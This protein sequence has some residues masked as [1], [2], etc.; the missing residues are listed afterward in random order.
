MSEAAA[1]SGKRKLRLEQNLNGIRYTI[2]SWDGKDARSLICKIKDMNLDALEVMKQPDPLLQK[3]SFVVLALQQA[4]EVN[5]RELNGKR[6][7]RITILDKDL[8]E[9]AMHEI[10]LLPEKLT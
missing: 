8:Y 1:M 3:I 7:T 4:T 10:H 5:V 9:W 2:E 6:L